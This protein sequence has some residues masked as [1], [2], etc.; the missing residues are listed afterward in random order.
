MKRLTKEVVL[1]QATELFTPNVSYIV[2]GQPK[3]FNG[4]N[5]PPQ[6]KILTVVPGAFYPVAAPSSGLIRLWKDPFVGTSGI[7]LWSAEE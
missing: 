3:P 1:H 2:L 7:L 5:S 6:V 4:S